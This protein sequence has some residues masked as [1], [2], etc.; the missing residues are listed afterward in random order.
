ML[1]H[2]KTSLLFGTTAVRSGR[3]TADINPC[4]NQLRMRDAQLVH[5]YSFLL[6]TATARHFLS[7]FLAFFLYPFYTKEHKEYANDAEKSF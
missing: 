3:E 1:R 4:T 5:S 2:A 7:F 6:N